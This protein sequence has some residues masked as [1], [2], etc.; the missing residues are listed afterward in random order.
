MMSKS[1]HLKLH[2]RPW[3]HS[4]AGCWFRRESFAKPID[5]WNPT[6]RKGREECGT[7]HEGQLK[8]SLRLPRVGVVGSRG[9]WYYGAL[10]GLL[11]QLVLEPRSRCLASNS[12]AVAIPLFRFTHQQHNLPK[13]DSP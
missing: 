9:T 6:S 7:R 8:V 5:S 2:P 12:P 1:I 10:F 4:K 13:L 3:V 11:G